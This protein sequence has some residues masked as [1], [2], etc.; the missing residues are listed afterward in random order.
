MVGV[1]LDQKLRLS[2]VRKDQKALK[3]NE[4]LVKVSTCGICG[5]DNHIIKGEARVSPPVV[6]G[7]EFGGIVI[8]AGESVASVR[9]GG[10]VAIDPN[11]PC[12]ACEYCRDGN[13]HLCEKLTAIGIDIDGGMSDRCAVPASQVYTVPEGFD[14]AF[15]PFV[16]PLSCVLHGLDRVSVRHGE[17]VLIIGSGT[18]G[19]MQLLMLRD[20]AG[21]ILVDEVNPSRLEKAVSLGAGKAGT[22]REDYFDA[23]I[24]CSGTIT[25]FNKAISCVRPGGRILIF[26]VTPIED[27]A[28]IN[29]NVI[30]RK[31]LSIMG[32]YVNPNTF[33][34]AIAVIAGGKIPLSSLEVKYFKLEDFSEAFE[35]SRSGDYSKVAFRAE[36]AI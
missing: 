15:L 26:G 28:Q 3:G 14:P 2:L 25:G 23:V 29:P 24:E 35:A 4:V 10:L 33:K 27:R 30:Y 36:G 19:L 34:R 21:E 7:H 17:R 16:E 18:I 32:S 5:T 11:I 20:F 9:P 6:L 1:E 8:D 22:G 31:E 12:Y 13:T